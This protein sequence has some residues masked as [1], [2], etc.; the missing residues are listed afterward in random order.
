MQ[1][2]VTLINCDAAAVLLMTSV[3][4]HE[5]LRSALFEENKFHLLF[6]LLFLKMRNPLQ[7]IMKEV[8]PASQVA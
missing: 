1:S 6:H 3:C 2:M 8:Q 4:N 7:F 5:Q